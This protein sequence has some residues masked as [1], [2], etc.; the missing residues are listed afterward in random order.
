MENSAAASVAR[1]RAGGSNIGAEIGISEAKCRV[2]QPPTLLVGES[3]HLPTLVSANASADI[4]VGG[5]LAADDVAATIVCGRLR[6]LRQTNLSASIWSGFP[7][8]RRSLGRPGRAR[9][10]C[11]SESPPAP[12]YR[13]PP[14]RT[15]VPRTR[16]RVVSAAATFG[17][18]GCAGRPGLGFAPAGRFAA[19]STWRTESPS[20]TTRCAS[21]SIAFAS[22]SASNARA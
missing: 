10:H 11:D 18:T 3:R 19:D 5:E 17:S 21:D 12:S 20:A 8:H 22:S 4:I 15:F 13:L 14:M 9:R 2:D 16:C 1:T 7:G 6:C